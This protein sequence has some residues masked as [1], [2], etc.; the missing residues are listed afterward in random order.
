MRTL[1]FETPLDRIRIQLII[2]L[3]HA[4]DGPNS[5]STQLTILKNFEVVIEQKKKLC[6]ECG[7]TKSLFDGFELVDCPR[8]LEKA[9]GR[10]N[11]SK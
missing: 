9:G 10:F 6:P 1:D 8:C 2:D 7:G 11:Q 5:M 4:Q 3:L